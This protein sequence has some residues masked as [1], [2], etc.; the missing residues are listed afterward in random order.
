MVEIIPK[1][2]TKTPAKKGFLLSISIGLLLISLVGFFI[3]KN[4]AQQAKEELTNLEATFQE[5]KSQEKSLEK[6]VLGFRKK[7]NNF[8]LLLKDH[9][10]ASKFFPILEEVAHPEI[11][12]KNLDLNPR[13][14]KVVISGL[15][16]EFINLAEQLS[17]LKNREE[18]KNVKLNKVGI[19]Q[20]KVEFEI[21]I[22][23]PPELFN[24]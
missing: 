14:K 19:S 9:L 21:E 7:L 4:I 20:E 5:L 11:Q 10:V 8:S 18:T 3:L 12:F 15:T 13:Q 23:L 17:I 22:S 16:D 2:P 1:A 24:F 6:E